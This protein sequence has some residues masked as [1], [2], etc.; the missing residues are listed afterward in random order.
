MKILLPVMPFNPDLFSPL[1]EI[2]C[3]AKSFMLFECRHE[4]FSAYENKMYNISNVD[5]GKY[6]GDLGVNNVICNLIC[7]SCYDSLRA[8]E[9]TIWYD[10]DS[11][12]IRESCQRFTLGDLSLYDPP[13]EFDFHEIDTSIH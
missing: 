7:K 10:K 6:L 9:I 3:N 5:I 12:S 11:N 2:F 1:S 13:T 4:T 8:S